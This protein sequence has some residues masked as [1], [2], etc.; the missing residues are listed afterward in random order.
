[1]N[2]TLLNAEEKKVKL[3]DYKGKKIL[4]YFYPK[5]LTPGCTVQAIGLN[6]ALLLL[7][8]KKYKVIG[9]S[10]D[11]PVKLKKFKEKYNLEF[12][13]LSDPDFSACKEFGVYEQKKF[14]GKTYMGIVRTTFLIDEK[15]KI[16]YQSKKVKTKTHHTD[17]L[18]VI[19]SL[20]NHL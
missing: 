11:L 6:E 12:E 10:S 1:M 9:I 8:K 7:N 18:T 16:I 17:I 19:D 3:S 20:E 4:L 5:A 15:G 14:M 13:L 2:F